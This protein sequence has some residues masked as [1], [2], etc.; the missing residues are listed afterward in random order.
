MIPMTDVPLSNR[1]WIRLP[2]Q[3]MN[4]GG[5]D[6]RSWLQTWTWRTPNPKYHTEI[7]LDFTDVTFIEPWALAL[8]VSY[9]LHLKESFHISV[10]AVLAPRNPSNVYIADMG[11]LHVLANGTSTPQWDESHQ[12]TGLHVIKT[13]NDVTRFVESASRLGIDPSDETVDALKYSMAEMGRNVVQHSRSSIGGISIAQYFPERRAIQI[14]I[15]DCGWGIFNSLK[16]TYPELQGNLESLKLAVLP[17]VSGAFRAGTY[18]ASENAGLGLFFTKEIAWR[19]GGTFWLVSGDSLLGVVENDES[20]QSRHYKQILRWNGAAVTVDLPEKGVHDFASLLGL[21]REL[22][23]KAR[24]C[25]GAA[26]LD[27]LDDLPSL[28]GLTVISVGTF[29]EDVEKA[30]HIRDDTLIPAVTEGR[31]VVLDFGGARFVTQSFIHAL[32]ND[33]LR[34]PGS[35][36][37]LSFVNCTASTREAITMVAA[38]AASYRQCIA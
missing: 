5:R 20:A 27:F 19:A 32:L 3:N 10:R 28:E 2:R 21:C 33:V 7:V 35:L 36:L 11:L 24:N 29:H 16:V 17:H 15:T 23:V 38:Y 9:A 34:I 8:F 12:N 1:F 37:R 25:S 4:D 6:M 14:A 18:S 30:A 22:A 13:H 26:G 31:L